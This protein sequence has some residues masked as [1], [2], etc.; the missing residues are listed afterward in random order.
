RDLAGADPHYRE[1]LRLRPDYPEAHNNLAILLQTQGDLE[2]ADRHYTEALRLR[3]EASE[4]HYNYGLLL[5]AQGAESEADEQFRM[6]FELAP[7]EWAAAM[8]QQMETEPPDP[9]IN[10]A[11]LS[12]RELEVLRLVAAGRTNQDIADELFISVRTVAHHVTSILSKTESSNR[13]EAAAYADR[14]R[15]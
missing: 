2:G 14:L 8:K 7:P 9:A 6:A 10:G 13:T 4:T 5:K 12:Q 1:A 15:L 3:P 11:G